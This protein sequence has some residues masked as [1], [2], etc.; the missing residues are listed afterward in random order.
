MRR[1]EKKA[2]PPSV[3]TGL[4]PKAEALFIHH[5]GLPEGDLGKRLLRAVLAYGESLR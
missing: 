4:S 5:L 3:S 2:V 1:M